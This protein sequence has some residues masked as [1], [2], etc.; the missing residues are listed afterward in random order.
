MCRA[1]PDIARPP[2]EFQA[3]IVRCR[4]LAGQ[5]PGGDEV[6]GI[7]RTL[8]AV[9]IRPGGVFRLRLTE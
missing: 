6:E 1:A 9:N 7:G 3:W 2:D 5:G 8:V 4:E